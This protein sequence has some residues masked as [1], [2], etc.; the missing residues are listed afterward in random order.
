MA[1]AKTLTQSPVSARH[2]WLTA[3]RPASLPIAVGPVLVGATLGYLHER[4][5]D[6][7]AAMLVLGVAI[8]MQ[9]IT[10]LQNDVGYT[11]RGGDAVAGRIGMP[12]ATAL[13]W[14]STRDV[15][16]AIVLLSSLALSLGMALVWYRGWP[17][18]AIGSASLVA[19]LAYMGG[20]K[21]I[22]YSPY[23][24]LT[25]FVF[26]GLVAVMGTEWV[27]TGKVSQMGLLASASMGCL[28]A[29]ALAVNNHRDIDHDRRLGRQTFAATFG[30]SASTVLLA[31]VLAAPFV[32]LAALA[33][34]GG[35]PVMLLPMVLVP[36][37]LGVYQ[38]FLHCVPGPAY[39]P[40]VFR[41]FRLGLWFGGL[42][43]VAALL[44]GLR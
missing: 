18:L 23:G 21:P 7:V 3:I 5:I 41:T 39:N 30:R 12:R 42:L 35:A 13:G 8:L 38:D 34:L 9:V 2:A 15:R 27:L 28:A 10:N 26:F 36:H 16:V 22:A 29:A 32:L 44:Q 6:S 31:V 14:L 17:V 25:V 33:L 20:P 11:A 4:S 40:I 24:E 43:S 19:A 37:T 1:L